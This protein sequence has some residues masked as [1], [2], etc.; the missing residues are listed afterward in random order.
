[1]SAELIQI[2]KSMNQKELNTQLALQCAP[3]LTKNKISNLF[4]VAKSEKN[5]VIKLFSKTQISIYVLYETEKKVTFLLYRR[6]ELV[7]YLQDAPVTA[8]MLQLGYKKTGVE[9]ILKELKERYRA[10]METGKVFPH[11]LGIILEYPVTDVCAFIEN[12]GKNALYVGYWKVYED[13]PMALAI[14]RKYDIAK[15]IL[16][17][18]VARGVS[19]N[20]ILDIY[21]AVSFKEQEV[22]DKF[23]V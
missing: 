2:F 6:Q 11:E 13:L 16:L 23:I 14:F 4:I 22:V 3:L 19:L 15:E 8:F 12:Q 7:C 10:H 1:M 20:Q 18:M 5:K 9:S 17:R 21:E